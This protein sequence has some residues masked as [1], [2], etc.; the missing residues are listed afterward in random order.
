MWLRSRPMRITTLADYQQRMARVIEHIDANLDALLP[1][2]SLARIASF[3]PYHF[4][5]IFRGMVGETVKG[6]VKRLR[7]ERAAFA[8]THT[9]RPVTFVALEAGYD[10]AE[11]FTRAFR[12]QFGVSPQAYRHRA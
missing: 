2:E 5:R 1:I 11:A 4:H 10:A 9:E 3:S 8:L 6:Y 12:A 7:L